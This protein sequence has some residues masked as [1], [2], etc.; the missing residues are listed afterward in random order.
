MHRSE[1]QSE[2]G[3]MEVDLVVA[4]ELWP[5]KLEMTSGTGIV[6]VLLTFMVE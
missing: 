3:Q 1:E 5:T 6:L 4:L 2:G